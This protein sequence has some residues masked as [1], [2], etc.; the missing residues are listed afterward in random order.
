MCMST[1]AKDKQIAQDCWNKSLFCFGTSELLKIRATFLKNIINW[2]TYAGVA[3][4]VFVGGLVL[5]FD[6]SDNSLSYIK[7][8][9]GIMNI[10]FILFSL[11]IIVWRCQDGYV[12]LSQ[13][14]YEHSV[15]SEKFQD[16][17]RKVN[18]DS[19][20]SINEIES[21]YNFLKREDEHL[22][23]KINELNIKECEKRYG[24]RF[25]L[26]QFQRKCTGCDEIPK[27]LLPTDCSVCGQFRFRFP[28]LVCIIY[29]TKR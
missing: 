24:M 29:D 23:R 5:C 7:C 13:T 4:P 27:D 11:W 22:T 9:F 6:F 19:P 28:L 14:A 15:L 12:N 25:A 18:C 8:T 10:P 17:A 3:I 16:L 1:I 26:R 20:P 21:E 2:Q